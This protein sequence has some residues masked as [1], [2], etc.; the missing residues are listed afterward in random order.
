[1]ELQSILLQAAPTVITP[2]SVAWR[3]TDV[4]YV[5]AGVL[6]VASGWFLLQFKVQA[7][8]EKRINSETNLNARIDKEVASG[9]EKRK[10]ISREFELHV[11]R[12]K[13]LEERIKT[14][15]NNFSNLED[16]LSKEVKELRHDL[17]NLSLSIEKMKSEI[18]TKIINKRK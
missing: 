6:S 8:E 9:D 14:V 13:A 2:D 12:H 15:E 18:L 1:M 17:Q 5:I 3:T 10:A 7:L 16:G 4:I 11:E